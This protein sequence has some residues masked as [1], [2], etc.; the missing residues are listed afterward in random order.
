P[1]TLPHAPV[2]DTRHGYHLYTILIDKQQTGIERDAFLDK[3]TAHNIGVGVHYL[4]IPEH[5]FYQKRFGWNPENYPNAMKIG[6]ET[7]SLPLS[8][9]LS[10]T[11]VEYVISGVKNILRKV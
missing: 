2:S 5:P 10:E 4:S 9:K 8:P 1:V 3:M 6:R 11:A 7:V